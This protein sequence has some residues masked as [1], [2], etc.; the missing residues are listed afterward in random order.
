MSIT[1]TT[2]WNPRGEERRLLELLA[3][4]RQVYQHIVVV[5]PPGSE[6]PIQ[7]QLEQAGVLALLSPEWSWGRYLA[8][9]TALETDAELIHYADMDRLLRWVETRPEEWERALS[10][11]QGKDCVVF[12]RTE[13]AYQTHPQAMLQ[14]EKISNLVASHF[15]GRHLDVSAGSK[16]FSRPAASF[17]VQ[18]TQPRR[19][20]G[21]DAEWLVLLK[22]AGFSIDELPVDGL[23]YESADRFQEQAAD[24]GAQRSH[25]EEVD[26]DP[27]QWARRVEIAL[28]IVESALEAQ[29]AIIPHVKNATPVAGPE[30]D[31][32][33]VTFDLDTVFSVDDYLYFYSDALTDERTDSEVASIVELMHLNAPLQILDL[34]CG[35]GRHTNRLAALGHHMT[36]VDYMPG[37][38]EI[39]RRDA[40]SRHLHVNYVRADMREISYHAE[41][42]LVLILFTAF[43]YF[44]D[45][46]NLQVM[47]NVSKAL[48]P[49]GR[50][51]FDMPNRDTFLKMRYPSIVTEKD[52]NLMIDRVSFDLLTG[53]QINRRILIRDGV[54]KDQP[55]KIRLYNPS[56]IRDLLKQAGLELEMIYGGWDG[57]PVSPDARRLIIIGRK[58]GN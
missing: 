15:L 23:D 4:L 49:D 27:R 26:A 45:E 38:L 5:F 9:K 50:L 18:L 44:D 40:Q 43:G 52:G 33:T 55:F 36:G 6:P 11:A 35:F 3:R 13:A 39:A 28:E 54:R 2:T 8:L 12:T 24:E 58:P 34:A 42:D 17:L 7:T 47:K 31:S 53:Q 32:S 51:L 41:F 16:A 48:R 21:T 30:Y 37:F 14:T 46:E 19:S 56:E 29:K 22:R 1:L 10:F 20:M 57:Q 25:A